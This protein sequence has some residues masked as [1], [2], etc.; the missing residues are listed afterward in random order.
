MTREKDADPSIINCLFYYILL[1]SQVSEFSS[2]FGGEK[3]G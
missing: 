1:H 3:F 2:F